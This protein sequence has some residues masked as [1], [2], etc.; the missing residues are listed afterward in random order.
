MLPASDSGEDAIGV[1]GPDEGLGV[2]IGFLDEA[3][4]GGLKVDN[5]SEDATFE[6]ASGQFGEEAFDSI[7]PGCGCWG[8][9]ERPARMAC[10]PLAHFWVLVGR[11]IVDDGVDYLSHGDLRLDR[12]EE[13][14]ELLVPMAL[15]VAADDG[16]VKN[17]KGSK[18]LPWRL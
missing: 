11:I 6:A 2:G 13:A 3:V 4:D 17:V 16:A 10:Q 7:E 9:V 15:H 5:G 14:D 18:Q 1:G 8:E 12:I